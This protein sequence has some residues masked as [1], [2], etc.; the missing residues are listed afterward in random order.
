M[1][2]G[3]S[4]ELARVHYN[5][6]VKGDNALVIVP[7]TDNRHGVGKVTARSGEEL[8]AIAVEPGK[9]KEFL[10]DYFKVER[11]IVAILLD[12]VQFFTR[13]DIFA[14]KDLVIF[15]DIPVI[16]YGLKTDFQNNLFEGSAAC[17]VVAEEII[18]IET[19]CSFCNRRAIMNLRM[20]NGK[21]VREGE[22]IQI[23]DDEYLQVC[24]YH[25]LKDNQKES[26]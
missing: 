5:Y 22:Q 19:V 24:H 2:A 9:M 13:D 3:K 25:Y 4:Q 17:L 26:L 7:T 20:N 15:Q 10:N 12:E 23:G 18:E 21:P 8:D 1:R 11:D 6:K 16:A 14:L